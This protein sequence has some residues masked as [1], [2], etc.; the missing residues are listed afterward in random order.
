MRQTM[1]KA[2]GGQPK[3]R[4]VQAKLAHSGSVDVEITCAIAPRIAS[5]VAPSLRRC[6]VG[7]D[8]AAVAG[9]RGL[10]GYVAPRP[11]AKFRRGLGG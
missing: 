4:K 3:H 8:A 1:V 5:A 11:V 9:R 7:V 2:T 6:A 10:G